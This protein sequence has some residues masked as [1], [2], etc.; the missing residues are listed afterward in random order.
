MALAF[1]LIKLWVYLLWAYIR[2]TQQVG[3]RILS[4]YFRL[5]TLLEFL[6]PAV[7]RHFPKRYQVI[8]PLLP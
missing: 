5:K 7:E 6:A 3:Q 8:L 4:Q 2:I 1:V